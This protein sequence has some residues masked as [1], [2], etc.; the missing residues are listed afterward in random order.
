[1]GA[2]ALARPGRRRGG[3]AARL[4]KGPLPPRL[5]GLPAGPAQPGQLADSAAGRPA[6]LRDVPKCHARPLQQPSHGPGP[7]LKPAAANR[8]STSRSRRSPPTTCS[9]ARSRA[10][11]RPAACRT[12]WRCTRPARTSRW[13]ASGLLQDLAADVT[14]A[15]KQRLLPSTRESGVLTQK[16]ID[17]VAADSRIKNGEDGQRFSVPFTAGAFGIVYANKD[18]LRAAGL[19]P[20]TPP[21]SWEEFIKALVGAI[22]G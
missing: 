17:S 9:S 13:G 15:W 16:K 12:C 14:D 10:P 8:P 6:A 18:K 4:R 21:A 5:P 22:K 2:R 11:R 20:D 7:C 19:D 1:M 3:A